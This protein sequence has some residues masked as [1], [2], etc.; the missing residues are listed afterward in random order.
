MTDADT[1]Q[2]EKYADNLRYLTLAGAGDEA[3]TAHLMEA[4]AG[5]VRS[6]AY[7]FSGR[8]AELED[9]IQIGSIGMLKAIRSFDTTRGTA[10]STYAVPLIFGEIR[11]FLRDDG[12]IKVGRRQKKLGAVLL[13]ARQRF[14]AEYGREPQ[15]GELAAA[16][17]VTEADAVL[18]LDAI[19]P[20][21]S[22]SEPLGGEDPSE[23]F[24]LE[25]VLA[26]ED[27]IEKRIDLL[28]LRESLNKLPPLWR[29]IVVLRYFRELSQQ[30]T[31]D[32]LG[33]TQ[34]KISR[35]EKKI[36]DFLR[37]ELNGD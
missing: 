23:E 24:A 6:V 15:L 22:L 32:R 17:S 2:E 28:A 4:N 29:R 27:V 7:R 16:C 13:D 34:V 18:A 14:T 8:G 37:K 19:A 30:Q 5:L 11:R 36:F 3:A 9:L 33:L 31:A 12:P 21:H 26:D 1:V 10:F 35:E 25:Q 20:V